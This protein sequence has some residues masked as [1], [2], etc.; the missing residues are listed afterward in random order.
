MDKEKQPGI[1][2]NTVF[3]KEL[4]FRRKPEINGAE[5][6]LSFNSVASFSEDKK[7]LVYELACKVTDKSETFHI[8]CIMVGIFTSIDGGENMDLLEFSKVNAP[9]L[10]VSLYQGTSYDYIHQGGP[11]A[12]RISPD[13]CLIIALFEM[14]LIGFRS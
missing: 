8:D 6:N 1:S 9:A 3:L 11:G 12:D 13:Q 4:N 2:F 5:L 14:R 7:Q 10:H